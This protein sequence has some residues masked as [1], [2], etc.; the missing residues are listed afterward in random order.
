MAEILEGLLR[1]AQ[2]LSPK[3]ESEKTGLPLDDR[4]AE[5]YGMIR[6]DFLSQSAPIWTQRL[7]YSRHR[8]LK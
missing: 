5:E 2:L 1:P 3:R 6:A 8:P 7:D 4:C